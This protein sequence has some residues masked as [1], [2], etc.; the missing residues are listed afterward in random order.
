MKNLKRISILTVLICLGSPIANAQLK[1]MVKK[2]T[3]SE[4]KEEPAKTKEEPVKSNSEPVKTTKVETAT[5]KDLELDWTTFKMTPAITMSSLLYGTQ[6]YTG[7]GTSLASYTASFVPYLKADGTP[8]STVYDQGQYL[9]VKVYKGN[10][11]IDYFEYDGSQTFEN[12]KLRKFNEP[13]SRYMKNG[14]WADGT[15]IDLKKWGEGTYRLEFYAGS[16]LFY[17][18]EFE[19][20]KVTNSD[21]YAELNEMYLSRGPW[22]KYAWME[23]QSSGNMVFGFYLQHEE[24]KPNAADPNKTMKDVSWTINITKDGKPFATQYDK[25][26]PVK[27]K[28]ERAEWKEMTTALKSAD[29]TKTIQLPD[30]TDG[31]YKIEVKVDNE[32]KPR[33]YN[34]SVAGGKIILMDEQD[35]TKNT[36]P[37]RLVEGWNNFYW[38]KLAQ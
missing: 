29:G 38:F 2:A 24:F 13:G 28:V 35:R 32:A 34:F 27:G 4:S 36:D 8:V 10:E 23:Q 9:K 14:D 16:K 3:Q 22:N 19:V 26:K 12:Q 18:F 11:F 31:K 21:P 17:N 5:P 30:F 33:I 37:T 1:S 20:Y 25:T 15:N 6:V 7:G